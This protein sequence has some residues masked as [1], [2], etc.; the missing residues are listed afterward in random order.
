[1]LS[2]V[3]DFCYAVSKRAVRRE[4]QVSSYRVYSEE[5]V[6]EAWINKKGDAAAVIVPALADSELQRTS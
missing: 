4:K 5:G 6:H 1:M 2:V 3:R